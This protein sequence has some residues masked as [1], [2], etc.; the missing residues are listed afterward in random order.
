[1]VHKRKLK[2]KHKRR[3]KIYAYHMNETKT[4]TY[5]YLLKKDGMPSGAS[6]SID[7]WVSLNIYLGCLGHPQAWALASPPPPHIETSSIFEHFIHTKLNWT[8][9]G[10]VSEYGNEIPSCT[11]VTL[12]YNY[13]KNYPLYAIT[14]LWTQVKEASR[15]IQTYANNEAITAICENRTVCKDLNIHHTSV[16]LKIL[17]NLG[18]NK[19]FYSETVQK[20]SEPFDIL[21]KKM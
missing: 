14:I 19:H 16:T 18:K 4:K 1:M 9:S 11:S 10:G 7:A 12:L 6:P 5:R 2:N 3:S 8:F 13:K 15:R 21:V 20:V 17:K